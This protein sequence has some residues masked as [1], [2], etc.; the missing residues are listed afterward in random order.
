MIP[1]LVS[2][3]SDSA[4]VVDDIISALRLI[5]KRTTFLA[6][7][8]EDSHAGGHRGNEAL[9]QDAAGAWTEIRGRIAHAGKREVQQCE[10]QQGVLGSFSH[11][12]IMCAATYSVNHGARA[13]SVNFISF[14]FDGRSGNA[15]AT[16]GPL[17]CICLAGR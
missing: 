17:L 4:L 2:L 9:K 13:E 5:K 16:V 10:D 6:R 11:A 1:V 12:R 14:D 3:A 7:C 15:I 8:R